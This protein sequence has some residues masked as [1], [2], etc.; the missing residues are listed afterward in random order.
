MFIGIY[1]Q[2]QNQTYRDLLRLQAGLIF[3]GTP[4]LLYERQ[5]LW[6]RL[7]TLLRLSGITNKATLAQAD[8]DKN[9]IANISVKFQETGLDIHIISVYEQKKTKI[10]RGLF[11]FPQVKRKQL[12]GLVEF[13]ATRIPANIGQ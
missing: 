3:L 1:Q 10:G 11:S 9:L 12:V 4:H 2:L 13:A 6:T 5:H 7:T 8:L